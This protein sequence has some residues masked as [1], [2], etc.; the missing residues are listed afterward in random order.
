MF[1]AS[2]PVINSIVTWGHT[3]NLDP[4]AWPIID[5][6]QMM[7]NYAVIISAAAGLLYIIY[8]NFIVEAESRYQY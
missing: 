1:A 8:S 4:N 7:W 3:Q 2:Q 5:F 6:V